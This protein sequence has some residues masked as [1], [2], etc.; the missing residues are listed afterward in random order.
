LFT[1]GGLIFNGGW[2][3][4]TQVFIGNAPPYLLFLVFVLLGGVLF[5]WN[6]HDHISQTVHWQQALDEITGAEVHES[7][8]RAV[9]MAAIL[10]VIGSV[11]FGSIFYFAG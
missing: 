9:L 5:L 1:Y 6:L 4:L 8:N 2:Q 7:G 10:I 3:L 11:V